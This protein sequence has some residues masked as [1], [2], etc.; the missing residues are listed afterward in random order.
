MCDHDPHDCCQFDYKLDLK[1]GI[2]IC[3]NPK[4][5]LFQTSIT[6]QFNFI[7]S[8]SKDHD[9]MWRGVFMWD[10]R[11]AWNQVPKRYSS[12]RLQ[13]ASPWPNP[14]LVGCSLAVGRKFF[15]HIGKRFSLQISPLGNWHVNLLFIC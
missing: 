5:L 13:R 10:M 3:L 12:W 14:V 9:D 8:G 15:D 2:K 6:V 4:L 7:C 11:Y 1:K